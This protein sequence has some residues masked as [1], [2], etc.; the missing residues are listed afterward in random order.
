MKRYNDYNPQ[1]SDPDTIVENNTSENIDVADDNR[2]VKSNS[3]NKQSKPKAI[4]APKA[5]QSTLDFLNSPT[6]RYLIGLISI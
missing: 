2:K 1:I 6:L 4:K 5:W 3:G